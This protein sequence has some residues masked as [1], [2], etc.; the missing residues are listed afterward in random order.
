MTR[1]ICLSENAG[2]II[3]RD[4]VIVSFVVDD[5]GRNAIFSLWRH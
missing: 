1:G 5:A 4:E 2:A 3:E